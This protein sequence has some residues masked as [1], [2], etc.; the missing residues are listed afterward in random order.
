ML[1]EAHR[2]S[3]PEFWYELLSLAPFCLTFVDV[4]VLIEPI[5]GQRCVHSG[6]AYDWSVR[7]V[8][9]WT[10][11]LKK[12]AL[13]GVFSPLVLLWGVLV[14]LTLAVT[15]EMPQVK[16]EKA[17]VFVDMTTHQPGCCT[18]TEKQHAKL[19]GNV[20]WW[21][22]TAPALRAVLPPIFSMSATD[23]PGWVSPVGDDA[24]KARK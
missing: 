2:R 14:N 4:R 22:T 6:D 19:A 24:T 9:G 7:R 12:L 13:K 3:G 21:A 23:S 1:S 20:Q 10:L 8:L 11:N 16:V 17:V 5:L 15:C 18:V